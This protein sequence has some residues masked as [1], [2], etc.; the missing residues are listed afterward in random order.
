MKIDFNIE[1]IDSLGQGVSKN[2]GRVSFIKK[3]LPGERGDATLI[4]SR[5]GVQFA[6]LNS[7][8]EA[9]PERISPECSHFTDCNGCDFLHTSYENEKN[10]KLN[11]LNRQLSKFGVEKIEYFEAKA[12]VGYRNRIQL[13]YDLVQKK[14]GFQ[15]AEY[16]IIEVPE[17]LITIPEIKAELKKLYQDQYWLTL[18]K[19]VP[20]TGHIELYFHSG[21]VHTNINSHYA[22]GGFTQVNFEMNKILN[23][24][25]S[26]KLKNS[27][28]ITDEV[29]D[30]FGGN[31]NLSKNI[32][33][34]TTVVDYY[35]QTPT[36]TPHQTFLSLDLYDKNALNV[37]KKSCKHIDWLIIDPP[38]SGIK[39]LM[40]YILAFSPKGF[41]YVSC[42][43][44]SFTRDTL[45][46]L[47]LYKPESIHLFDLFP[48]TH[49][50]ETVGIFTR[51]K[52]P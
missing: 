43:S 9:S 29:L 3:T 24:F 18:L 32:L 31:G 34:K 49:H 7:I 28:T 6:K 26:E 21:K 17:C 39:N 44:T 51:R 20:K 15:T 46:L 11:S 4:A 45:P 1:H 36:P 14:L 33:Q 16:K 23:Q 48:S 13:H 37:L 41:I 19:R 27:L 2:E 30:L 35:T 38:R 40:E 5:K 12:R 52:L 25:I 47:T 50:F 22:E 10:F 8:S 42:Q